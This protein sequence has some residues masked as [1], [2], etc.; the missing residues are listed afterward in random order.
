MYCVC[1]TNRIV[2]QQLFASLSCGIIYIEW[3]HLFLKGC[4]SLRT[5]TAR[6]PR[7]GQYKRIV[8]CGILFAVA[9]LVAVGA[10]SR[11]PLNFIPNGTPLRNPGGASE[12]YSTVGGGIDETGPFFQ[13]MG[14][15]GRSCATCHQPSDGM[16]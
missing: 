8:V 4:V 16:S 10:T 1:I 11:Q 5:I 2:S 6:P 9:M 3:R 13:S 14:T 12:T 7:S 15:N